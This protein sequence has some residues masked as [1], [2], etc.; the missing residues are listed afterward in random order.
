M[1]A[2]WNARRQRDR[3]RVVLNARRSCA[4]VNYAVAGLA[5]FV[6]VRQAWFDANG[7]DEIVPGQV[8]LLLTPELRASE[9]KTRGDTYPSR[10]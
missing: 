2:L 4:T 1:N 5:D 8:R 7:G 10:R 3:A 9:H 6:S